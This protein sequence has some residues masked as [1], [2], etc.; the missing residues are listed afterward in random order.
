MASIA[1]WIQKIKTAI[2]GEE[3]RGAIWQSLQAMNDELTS[4]DVTQIPKNKTAIETLQTDV[5]NLKSSD[6]ELKDIRVGADGTQYEN[7][8]KAV[9]TQIADLKSYLYRYDEGLIP[10]NAA[11]EKGALN[12]DGTINSDAKWR[13]VTS[14]IISYDKTIVFKIES[15]YNVQLATFDSSGTFIKRISINDGYILT[16]GTRFRISIYK[17]N[18]TVSDDSTYFYQNIN[19]YNRVYG[20][21]NVYPTI[22]NSSNYASFLPDLNEAT[23]NGTVYMIVPSDGVPANMPPNIKTGWYCVLRVTKTLTAVLQEII[24]ETGTVYYRFRYNSTSWDRWIKVNNGCYSIIN[25]S[26]YETMMPDLNAVVDSGTYT[27]IPVSGAMPAHMPVGIK[28]NW[29]S[30]LTVVSAQDGGAG[31]MQEIVSEDGNVYRRFK[32]SASAWGDWV[33][34][35]AKTLFTVRKD[36]TGDYTSVLEAITT[37]VKYPNSTVYV[38]EGEYD[39][40]QEYKD[41]Y[42]STYFDDYTGS[43]QQYQG[44]NLYNG[45]TLIFSSTAKLVCHYTG[46]NA[47]V[48]R[49]FSCLNMYYGDAYLINVTL[50]CANIRYAV[51]DDPIINKD[52]AWK[53]EYHHCRFKIDYTNEITGISIHGIIGGGL[54]KRSDIIIEDCI[55]EMLGYGNDSTGCVGYHNCVLDNS[56]SNVIIKNCYFRNGTAYATWYGPSTGKSTF[57]VTGNRLKSQPFSKS[58][59]SEYNVKN[60]ELLAWNNEIS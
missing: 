53:H 27:I 41:K 21:Y 20:A 51:H 6:T 8:G 14:D 23:E 32:D 59:N 35:E 58:E 39:V 55:F 4:A 28:T 46:T 3:V 24:S 29:Y 33:R 10:I 34:N 52:R 44:I 18:E 26:N 36:G 25:N 45:I 48:R 43:S 37:A 12:S 16:S 40:I 31:T 13:L 5:T 9:R 50:D 60:V 15:G 30:T 56:L 11:W 47:A 42:G 54:G 1:E 17:S 22:I 38:D 57:L 19:I 49:S 7:A 2:Y